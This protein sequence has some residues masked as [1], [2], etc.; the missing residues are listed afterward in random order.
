MELGQ[1]RYFELPMNFLMNLSFK[2]AYRKAMK[3]S[4]R[5]QQQKGIIE[6]NNKVQLAICTDRR[7]L[8]PPKASPRR[9]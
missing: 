9:L 3:I 8:Q 2:H 5:T 4:N 1:E 7:V 6:S